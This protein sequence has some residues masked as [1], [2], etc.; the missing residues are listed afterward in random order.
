LSKNLVLPAKQAFEIRFL[1]RV[2]RGKKHFYPHNVCKQRLRLMPLRAAADVSAEKSQ[3]DFFDGPEPL[4]K[5]RLI[6]F[7]LADYCSP[8]SLA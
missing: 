8:F 7:S 4:R 2:S 6:V 1:P 3:R 5:G